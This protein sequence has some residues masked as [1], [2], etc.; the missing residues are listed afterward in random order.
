MRLAL[1]ARPASPV[2]PTMPVRK[3]PKNH[4]FV[5]GGF[6]SQKVGQQLGFESILEKELMLLL[7]FDANVERFEEQPVRVPVPGV[8]QGY[9]PDLL[10]HYKGDRPTEL[11]EVKTQAYLD[12]Y[13]AEYAP[14]F[15]AAGSYCDERG[16]LFVK[17]TEQDIRTPR[18]SNLKF[19][20]RYRNI[21]PTQ[22]EVDQV[23]A[24]LPGNGQSST[25]TILQSFPQEE[26]EAWLPVL[27]H[28]VLTHQLITNLDAELPVDV[29][30]QLPA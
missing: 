12:R 6:S 2:M 14:K 17:Y 25:E 29:A 22:D 10:V 15:A 19:L 11:V 8:R 28:M 26:R 1:N 21:E 23:L 7:E 5:T 3:I 4:L 9:V 13:A 18:L 30:V 16:W 20:R 27:W 24:R